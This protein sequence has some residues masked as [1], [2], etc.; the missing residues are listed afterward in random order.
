VKDMRADYYISITLD[1][2]RAIKTGRTKDNSTLEQP[3][4]DDR[5]YPVRLRVYTPP[6]NR[7]QKLYATK[8]E[9]T[10]SEYESVWETVKP[11]EK[12]KK[13]RGQMQSLLSKAENVAE[14]L[15]P[16]TLEQFERKLF[17]KAGDGI[18]VKKQYEEVIKECRNNDRL[19]SVNTYV[20][21]MKSLSKFTEKRQDFDKLTLYDITTAW[22]NDYE[23]YMI[24]DQ[25]KSLTSVGIYLRALKAVYNKAIT[26]GEID[27][28]FYPFGKRKYVIPKGRNVKKALN[29]NQLSA[30]FHSKAETPEQEKA[31][32]FWFF[33]YAC[34]GMNIKDIAHLKYSDI[35]EGVIKFYRAKTIN[36][37][38]GNFK[39]ITVHLNQYAQEIIMK[40]GNPKVS[41]NTYVFN[42][43]KEGM[44]AEE[45]YTKIKI[46]TRFIDQHIK[47]LGKINGLP[48]EISVNWARHSYATTLIR[49]GAS[50]EFAQEHLGHS[51]LKTTQNYFAGFD[52][53]TKKEFANRIMNFNLS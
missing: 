16:F 39:P 35:S 6:P 36:T 24:K 46:F 47:K 50:M 37:S 20:Y 19:G 53:E 4:G 43:I 12:Y 3:K 44:S 9:L 32:D 2:R 45:Q 51:N 15:Q 5:K 22:L 26:E 29:Q 1:I 41:P 49:E 25:G 11:R 7:R 10:K 8:F 21:S 38:K 28:E 42:I 30:L 27:R 14:D 34:N 13:L 52:T 31:R 17:R 40:Y 23:K 48:E 33:S 18:S